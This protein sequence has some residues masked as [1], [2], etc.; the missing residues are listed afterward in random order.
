MKISGIKTR[1]V[2]PVELELLNLASNI[3]VD[4]K[5]RVKFQKDTFLMKFKNNKGLYFY[6]NFKLKLLVQMG[7]SLNGLNVHIAKIY[8]IYLRRFSYL[9]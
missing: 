7:Y 5:Y 9:Y 6:K 1:R 4:H 8:F 3:I 2:F